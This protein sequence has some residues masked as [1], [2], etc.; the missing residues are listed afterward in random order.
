[1]RYELE[2]PKHEGELQFNVRHQFVI[3]VG[4]LIYCEKNSKQ[5]R[6]S[7]DPSK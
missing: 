4:P 6:F 1:L 3:N 2:D 7:L 5:H